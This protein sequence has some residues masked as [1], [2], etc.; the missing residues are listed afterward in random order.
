VREGIRISAKSNWKRCEKQ[1]EEVGE[2][3]E[4]NVKQRREI[5]ESNER[6]ERSNRERCMKTPR[7]I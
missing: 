5:Q 1:Q 3:I 7:E 6:D 2:V 4:R